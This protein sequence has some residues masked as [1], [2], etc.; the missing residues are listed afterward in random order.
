MKK[1]V[2]LGLIL[3]FASVV[4]LSCTT[5]PTKP[6]TQSDIPELVGKWKGVLKATSGSESSEQS[7]E[8]EIFNESLE[9]KWV[10]HGTSQGTVSHPFVA[11]LEN[12]RLILSWPKD[13]WVKLGLI[14]SNDKK[15]L[16]G[17]FRWSQWDGTLSFRKVE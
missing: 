4:L 9:G 8:L 11:K 12:G 15:K 3:L 2:I 1:R 14:K 6:L 17:P 7:T 16:E 5:I 13:R 10:I